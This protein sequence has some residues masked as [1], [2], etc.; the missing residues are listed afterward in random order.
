MSDHKD[1]IRTPLS[2]VRYLGAARS[3]TRHFWHQRL[4]S[5]ALIPLTIAAVFVVIG[6]LGRNHAAVVQILGSSPVAIGLLLFVLVS[7]YHMWLGMQTI[8]EDYVHDELPK[9]AALMSNTFFSCAIGL[10]AVF[11]ILKLSFGL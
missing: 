2:R 1:S 10:A 7:I 11:A 6:L 8:I 5:V 9:Y 4:T 3:G